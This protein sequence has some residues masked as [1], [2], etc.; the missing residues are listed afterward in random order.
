[1]EEQGVLFDVGGRPRQYSDAEGEL[2]R[3]DLESDRQTRR[4]RAA[5]CIGPIPEVADPDRRAAA[6]ADFSEF[7]KTYHAD[8]FY[9]PD[10]PAHAELDAAIVEAITGTDTDDMRAFA[11]PRGSGKTTRSLVAVQWAVLSGR[12][13]FPVLIAANADKAANLLRTI[14][15]DF[16]YN[17]TLAADFPEVSYPLIKL[18]NNKAKRFS[19]T[20]LGADGQQYETLIDY[21]ANKLVLPWVRT[22]PISQHVFTAFG[23]TAAGL[24]GTQFFNIA[25]SEIMR[26]D[27]VVVDDPQNDSSALSATQCSQRKRLL[28]AAVKF[29]R[30]PGK[31]ISIFMPCTVLYADDLADEYTDPKRKPRWRGLRQSM[32]ASMPSNLDAWAHYFDFRDELY[33]AG[34]DLAEISEQLNARYLRDRESLSAGAVASWEHN[35]DPG[36]VDAIQH[37]MHLY[38]DDQESFWSE[39]QNKPNSRSVAARPLDPDKLARKQLPITRGTAPPGAQHLVSFI[40]IQSEVLFF[41]T[42]AVDLA[43]SGAVIDY[44]TWPSLAGRYYHKRDAARTKA[45]SRAYFRAH[46]EQHTAAGAPFEAKIYWALKQV[47]EQLLARSYPVADSDTMLMHDY[48]GIDIRWGDSTEI[49]KRFLADQLRSGERRLIGC[50]GQYVGAAGRPL[51]NY[52]REPG[53]RFETDQHRHLGDSRWI[54]RTDSRGLPYLLNDV[55]ALKSF[56]MRRLSSPLGVAGSIGLFRA[57]VAEHEMLADHL[58]K[59]EYPLAVSA[60]D[61]VVD[62][63]RAAPA[64]PDNDFLDCA[65]GCMALASLA[66]ASIRSEGLPAAT[67]AARRYTTMAEMRRRALEKRQ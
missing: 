28:E 11:F 59:S 60:K 43:F 10:S 16:V 14:R 8:K 7:R 5:A 29:L 36:E 64:R 56:L 37:A 13:R 30:G 31:P 39:C 57:P 40:D 26:P 52:R 41:V 9:L 32:L 61:R 19:Q 58:A 47:A 65:A 6:V 33:Q 25:T 35:Y 3:R 46:P 54:R 55:N 15:E 51:S 34:G 49:A 18:E 23:I 21:D 22:S 42:V 27:L 44:G 24:R 4:N 2:R 17:D 12:K 48:L 66:G 1:M 45:L 53:W 62:E 63:W 50:H 38:R 20:Y 67:A